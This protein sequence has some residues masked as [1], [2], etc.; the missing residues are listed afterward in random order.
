MILVKRL[1]GYSQETNIT[2]SLPSSLTLI[3]PSRTLSFSSTILF[4][5]QLKINES[6]NRFILIQVNKHFIILFSFYIFQ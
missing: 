5:I 4:I 6:N 1:H 3:N 2:H